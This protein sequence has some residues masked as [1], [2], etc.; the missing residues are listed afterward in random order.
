MVSRSDPGTRRNR[1]PVRGTDISVHQ[2]KLMKIGALGVLFIGLICTQ[3]SDA[4]DYQAIKGSS[5]AGAM[6]A[7]DNPASILSTP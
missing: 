6:S 4:Q 7:S 2:I 1:R 3:E 5:Y